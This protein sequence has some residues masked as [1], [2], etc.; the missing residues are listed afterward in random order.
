M[1][2]C[3]WSMPEEYIEAAERLAAK[4]GI[5]PSRYVA[6]LIRK[7]LPKDERSKLPELRERGRPS[8]AKEDEGSE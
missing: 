4:K 2:R 3:F 1:A 6:N 5:S 7:S 8:K